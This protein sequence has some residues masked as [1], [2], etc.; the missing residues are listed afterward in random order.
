LGGNAGELLR[1]GEEKEEG[2]IWVEHGD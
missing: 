2:G 1:K